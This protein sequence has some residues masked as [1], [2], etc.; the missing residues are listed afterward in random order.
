MARRVAA[1]EGH[2]SE[3]CGIHE[4]HFLNL[5]AVRF[6]EH[7]ILVG[8]ASEKRLQVPHK[9]IQSRGGAEWPR[10][11]RILGQR[12]ADGG[13]KHGFQVGVDAILLG[14][15]RAADG[16][17]DDGAEGLAEVIIGEIGFIS[18]EDPRRM[19]GD[20][21]GVGTLVG[22]RCFPWWGGTSFR[23]RRQ[24]GERFQGDW[25]ARHRNRR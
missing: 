4:K 14:I 12:A 11:G 9:T 7:D 16:L 25:S 2:Q 22:H 21:P 20:L 1:G 6:L 18:V 13:A 10:G 15:H 24:G 17:L 19:N 23:R 3:A 8:A 5:E